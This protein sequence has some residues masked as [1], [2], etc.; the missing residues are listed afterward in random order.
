MKGGGRPRSGREGVGDPHP[1]SPLFKGREEIAARSDSNA[2]PACSS[3]IALRAIRASGYCRARIRAGLARQFVG[4]F[5]GR[6]AGV[7][8]QPAPIAVVALTLSVGPPPPGD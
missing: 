2:A 6:V 4:A 8:P 3:R 1:I 5:V 7:T